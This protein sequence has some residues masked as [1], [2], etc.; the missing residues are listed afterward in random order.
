[1]ATNE[2]T[3]AAGTD[4]R[5]PMLVEDDYDS[6]KIRIY[7]KI[8]L[9]SKSLRASC[10]KDSSRKG[11]VY[12]F[13]DHWSYCNYGLLSGF[14]RQ[15]HPPTTPKLRNSSILRIC[16]VLHDGH[17]V[18]NLLEEGSRT[19]EKDGFRSSKITKLL[20]EAKEKGDVLD[21]KRWMKAPMSPCS[22]SWPAL[23]ITYSATNPIQSMRYTPMDISNLFVSGLSVA[24]ESL[25]DQE[26]HLDSMLRLS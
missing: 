6:W 10:Q 13:V 1:M 16:T 22:L 20:K 12:M 2:E 4:T 19:Q 14:K 26:K 18:M 7:I 17:I 24:E 21:V 11:A 23:V 25:F 9:I 5:P 8:I 3:N 15:F